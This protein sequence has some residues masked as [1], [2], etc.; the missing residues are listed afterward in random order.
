MEGSEG[1]RKKGGKK[2]GRREKGR[3][4]VLGLG[5]QKTKMSQCPHP[6]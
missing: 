3:E 5:D 6:P 4:K 1:G 2:I